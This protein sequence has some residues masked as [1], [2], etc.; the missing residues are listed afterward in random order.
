M[1]GKHRAF[2]WR[3]Q[4]VETDIGKPDNAEPRHRAEHV[5]TFQVAATFTGLRASISMC[6]CGE[7]QTEWATS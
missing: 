1:T 6:E 5:H 4:S 3:P 2:F 7:S